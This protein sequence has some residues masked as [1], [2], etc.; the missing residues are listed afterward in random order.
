MVAKYPHSPLYKDVTVLGRSE[1]S[2][3][4]LDLRGNLVIK[5]SFSNIE[6]FAPE[7]APFNITTEPSIRPHEI[8]RKISQDSG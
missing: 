5:D 7:T 2:R 3:L 8:P 6:G 1:G 4:S